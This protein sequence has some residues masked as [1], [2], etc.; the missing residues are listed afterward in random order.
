VPQDDR[1]EGGQPC[2]KAGWW[3]AHRAA[4]GRYFKEGE[5]MPDFKT[6]Y[7]QTIWQWVEPLPERK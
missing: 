2:S 5:P 1:C 7:G 6:D 3:F 4:S